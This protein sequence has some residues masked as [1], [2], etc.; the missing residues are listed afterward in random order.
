MYW[1]YT[2]LGT[3]LSTQI[4]SHSL[5]FLF[6]DWV[7]LLLPRLKY[8]G[9]ISAHHNLC[10][11]GSSDSSASASQVAEITGMD[12]HTQLSFRIISRDGASPCWSGWSQ[13]LDPQ[14]ASA[15]QST[16]TIGVTVPG[17]ISLL[18]CNEDSLEPLRSLF[19]WGLPGTSEKPVSLHVFDKSSAS[20]TGGLGVW[21]PVLPGVTSSSDTRTS[22]TAQDCP[23]L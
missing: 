9:A 20:G 4:W 3:E 23:S 15:S 19:H 8:N 12:H 5:F 18:F 13:T 22:P 1:G 2:I 7:S 6:W 10:L 16:G 17:S 14:P 11:L 21:I